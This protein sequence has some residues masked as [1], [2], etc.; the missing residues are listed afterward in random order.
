M[1]LSLPFRISDYFR[2]ISHFFCIFGVLHFTFELL[3]N[4]KLHICYFNQISLQKVVEQKVGGCD[5][6]FNFRLLTPIVILCSLPFVKAHFTYAKFVCRKFIFVSCKTCCL[7]SH[8][9]RHVRFF[10]VTQKFF[11]SPFNIGGF[12]ILGDTIFLRML[13]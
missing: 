1:F 4:A 8:I 12:Q 9:Q 10:S 5:K 6:F 11:L 7:H 13:D 2:E 3:F